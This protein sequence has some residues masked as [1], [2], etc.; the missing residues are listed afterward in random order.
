MIAGLGTMC[1]WIYDVYATILFIALM[2][3]VFAWT[4][5]VLPF[6]TLR[7]GNLVYRGCMVWADIWFTLVFI[8][9]RNVHVQRQNKTKAYIFVLNHQSYLDAALIPKVIRQ[10]V[11]VLGKAETGRIPVF[12]SIYRMATVAVERG[13][14]QNRSASIKRMK[15]LL[16]KGISVVIFPEGTFF[17]NGEPL[18][19]FY[20][21]AFR[22]AIETGIP[23]KPIVLLDSFD[24]MPKENVFSLNPGRNRAIFLEEIPVTGLRRGDIEALKARVFHLMES[25]IIKSRASWIR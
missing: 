24:R 12:G 1:R 19:E 18:K 14:A 5:L 6:G 4:L 10:P 2:V 21:G 23:I 15:R 22:I 20:N 13:N 16:D 25:T 17:D 8:R 3:I 9:N 7:G 11:R